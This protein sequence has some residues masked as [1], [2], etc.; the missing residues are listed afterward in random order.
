MVEADLLGVGM[1]KESQY[2]YILLSEQ[3]YFPVLMVDQ[4]V[5]LHP[6]K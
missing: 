1:Q 3:I 4:I 6:W 5:Q 2:V